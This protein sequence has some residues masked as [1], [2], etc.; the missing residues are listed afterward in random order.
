MS[1][2]HRARM[3]FLLRAFGSCILVPVAIATKSLPLL[4]AAP[5][6]QNLRGWR[7]CA[8]LPNRRGSN[9]R[10]RGIILCKRLVKL[11]SAKCG[12]RPGDCAVKGAPRQKLY[13]NWVS[14]FEAKCTIELDLA[15]RDVVQVHALQSA[16]R[17]QDRMSWRA[18]LAWLF[19]QGSCGGDLQTSWVLHLIQPVE[20]A[21]KDFA[22]TTLAAGLRAK[23]AIY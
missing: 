13:P 4:A 19:G 16:L 3:P 11:D 12:N 7:C 17:M 22:M 1:V 23:A 15:A 21:W 8:V 10:Q 9:A 5:R 20:F 18:A 6:P 2:H 14:G